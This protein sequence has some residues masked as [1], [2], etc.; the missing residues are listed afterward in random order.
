MFVPTI[1]VLPIVGGVELS[2]SRVFED[3]MKFFIVVNVLNWHYSF[4][5][6]SEHHAWLARS[7][8]RTSREDQPQES[9]Q[10]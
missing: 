1:P 10:D 6:C 4:L 2:S 9:N 7:E 5:G 8:L 3:G